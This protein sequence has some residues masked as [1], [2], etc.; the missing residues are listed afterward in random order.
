MSRA[1]TKD[2]R[3]LAIDPSTRGFGFAILEGP[4]KLID[5]GVKETK[6]NKNRMTLKLVADLIER[7]QPSMVVV[8]DY[9]EKGSRRSQRVSELI[10][11]I[12]KLAS[13]RK[14][15][16]R[17]VSR[18]K[19]KLAFAE[20]GASNKHE[21]ETAIAGR[22]QELAPRLPRFRK[23]WMSED[24]RMSIFDAVA[25]AIAFFQFQKEN[26]ARA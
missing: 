8:E 13:N 9:Q 18:A 25:L 5:W 24:Y 10:N 16:V 4:E 14:I 12:S 6:K 19:V 11:D 2:I 21:I 23:P 3:V 22:F 20:S 26:G 7:Y 17:S 15:R 1:Y